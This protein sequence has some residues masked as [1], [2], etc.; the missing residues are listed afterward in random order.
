MK[1][2]AFDLLIILKQTDHV[3]VKSILEL[4]EKSCWY[5]RDLSHRIIRGAVE[6]LSHPIERSSRK[7]GKIRKNAMIKGGSHPR[8]R[9]NWPFSRPEA[10]SADDMLPGCKLARRSQET[11]ADAAGAY[12]AGLEIRILAEHTYHT[13]VAHNVPSTSQL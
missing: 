8:P 3:S 13:F 12:E 6:S 1:P 11:R 2:P 7:V 9:W 10:V 4:C 5:R